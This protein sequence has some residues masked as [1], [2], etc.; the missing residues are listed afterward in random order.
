MSAINLNRVIGPGM[1]FTHDRDFGDLEIG[2]NLLVD[3]NGWK[4]VAEERI[5]TLRTCSQAYIFPC[6]HFA[7]SITQTDKGH[8]VVCK[9]CKGFSGKEEAHVAGT[10]IEEENRV[11]PS[12]TNEGSYDLMTEC[13]VCKAK[14]CLEH[15]VISPLGHDWNEGTVTEPAEGAQDGTMTFK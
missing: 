7:H 10:K 11:E 5:K 4:P 14:Y 9:H 13:S 2:D 1:R 12:C 15:F 8:K 3:L 6:S